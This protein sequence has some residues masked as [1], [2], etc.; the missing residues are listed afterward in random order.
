MQRLD[1]LL[2]QQQL[3]ATRSQAQQL[4]SQGRVCGFIKGKWQ[5][6]SKAGLKLAESTCLR[7]EDD[8][9]DRY[10]SRAGMKLAAALAKAGL[11][12]TSWQVLDI[13]QSTG[14]FSDCL[15]QAGAGLVVGLD[16]GQQQ[17]H[18]SLSQHPR[19]RSLEKINARYL[20]AEQ[21]QQHSLPTEYDL[22]VMDVSFISQTLI[23]K[24]L[25]PLLKPQGWL[26]TLVKPQFEVGKDNIGKGG[27]VRNPALYQQVKEKISQ[28]LKDLNLELRY[29]LTS[30]LLGGDGNQEFLLVA[31]AHP[32][33]P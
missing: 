21:L 26:I 23:L 18:P 8:P 10:V 24:Q 33:A 22:I 12:V 1:L 5:P 17:L 16:V 6:V 27:V 28:Q 20:T 9:A 31:Q 13:G 11:E 7:V 30:P 4:I 3:A 15:L 32:E 25:P 29:W 19:L 2:V 14:G